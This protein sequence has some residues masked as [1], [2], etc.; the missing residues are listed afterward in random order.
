MAV[1][2][3]TAKGQITIPR[4]VRSALDIGA[5]DGVIFVVEGKRAVLVPVKRQTLTELYGAFPAT[6]PFP[7]TEEVRRVVRTHVAQHV[8]GTGDAKDDN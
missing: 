4:S 1:A 3:V 8:L 2:R 7:G 6:R 5:G